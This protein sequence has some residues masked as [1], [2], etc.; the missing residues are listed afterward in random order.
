MSVN[1]KVLGWPENFTT[2]DE[3]RPELLAKIHFRLAIPYLSSLL[4]SCFVRSYYFSQRN[5]LPLLRNA[6]EIQKLKATTNTFEERKYNL[7]ESNAQ[8]N[9]TR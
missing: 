2:K 8:R 3:S 6:E 5:F 7:I 1:D 4:S 9:S